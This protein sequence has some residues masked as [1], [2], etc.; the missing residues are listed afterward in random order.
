MLV[1]CP[2]SHGVQGEHTT[3]S[4]VEHGWVMKLPTA[5]VL[6]FLQLGFLSAVQDDTA[7]VPNAHMPGQLLQKEFVYLV[8]FV[9]T[10]KPFPQSTV[11]GAH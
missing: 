5:H 1:Y 10:Y 8:Q 11:H 9:S 3:S 4:P 6:Q 2:G 7:Y